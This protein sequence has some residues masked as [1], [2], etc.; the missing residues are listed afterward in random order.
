MRNVSARI[1][2]AIVVLLAVCQSWSQSSEQPAYLNTKLAPE[3]RA[4]DLVHRMTV[5]EKVT[6][7][8]NQSRAVP[9]LNIP[10]YDWW[11]EASHGVA[12]TSGITEYPNPTG[13][14]AT[15]DTDRIHQMAIQ[16]GTEGR[17]KNAQAVRKNGGHSNIFEGLDFWAPNI[18]IFRD[19]RW[20]RGQ[21]TFGEDPFL[22]S[23]MGV[24]YVTGMQ[25]DDPKYYRVIST[26]K[27][28]AVHSGPEPSRHTD[29]VKVSKHD[30][31][32]TYLP[33]FRATV[34]E[35]K[36]G[37]VM[38]A[39]NAINGQPACVN[40]FLL[41]DQLRGK[42]NFQGYVVS[43]CEAVVNVFRDHHFT[44]TQPEA[45]ALAIQ[46]GMDNECID[47][48]KVNDDHDYKPYYDAFKQ[49]IL[50]ESEIDTA[51]VRL[52]TARIKLGMFDPPEMVPYT[53]IDEKELD[54]PQHRAMALKLANEAMVLLKNDGTLPLKK[55]VTKIAVVG[56]LP[57]QTRYLLGNYN[58][59]P[60]HTVSV[61]EGLKAEFPDAEINFVPGT[62]FLRQDG[63]LVP[64]SALTNADGQPG[65]KLQFSIGN[66]FEGKQTDVASKQVNTVDL[67]AADIPQEASGKYPLN[68]EWSGFITAPD[69]G[70][71]AIGLRFK[72][73][74]ARV[75][76]DGKPIA[77]GWAGE[78]EDQAKT[79]RV[80]LD[81][82]KKVAIHASYSQMNA[83]TP[84]AQLIWEKYDPNP[85]P[86]AIEA[87]KNA[88]VVIAVMG[89]TSELEGEEMPV[90]EEGFKGGDRT[91]LDLP[92]PEEALLEAVAATG[93][94]VVLVLANGSAMAVN[95]ANDHANAILEGWYP[96]EEGGT[97]IA[98]TLSGK[99][100]PAG[101][102]PVTF[103]TGVDQLPD[104]KDY[105]MK[106]RTYR[107]FEGKP[108]YPFGY[109]LSYT[110]FA[111]KGLRLPKG[112][113]KAGDPL[114]AEVTLTNTGKVE[115]DEVAQLY[116]SF[117]NVPGAPLRALRSFRR[118]HLKPGE[119][120]TVR[121]DLKDRD[122]SM[123][124]EAG[125]PIIAEGKYSVSVGGGQPNTAAASV[126]G[127]FQVKGTKTLPE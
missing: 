24:A 50:K 105:A 100:N 19:P 46:R 30:E 116:L 111:Y 5:E 113:I 94:P 84:S 77:Q 53:K 92:K 104:F 72:S 110:T 60:S 39:Y 106:G 9:R 75:V 29:D 96:G 122:L 99:N 78:G 20:G 119:S 40:E 63:G 123:V 81:A 26:P 98:Q 71:Y 121:F 48:G 79:G 18:N 114:T 7:L 4:A 120:Q 90:N 109:G 8:V 88:D 97:A 6:Q 85:K 33:A 3:Q 22:T 34:T 117:P 118:V 42:W 49:G 65:L 74:F 115:G 87:A 45:S 89:I 41:Q 73:G 44:K 23:R 69:T 52:Y 35:A 43:D 124:N 61:M 47:F 86:E 10:T 57:D 108:L 21:E 25:G 1:L 12:N 66:R 27:H 32:D 67:N 37:S 54:S 83:G 51:L 31:L 95:W 103:Y 11:S 15:F 17:I 107:Y 76:V 112:A 101:R 38:C 93:K 126:A 70:E 64:A 59:T 125:E 68:S 55:N 127:T 16:I 28:F 36:A 58:G 91:S 2:I 80:H 102:L 82:G 13:L 14:A 56:P 62:Q